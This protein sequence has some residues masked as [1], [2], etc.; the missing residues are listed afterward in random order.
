MAW[1]Q[2]WLTR[3]SRVPCTIEE[4]QAMLKRLDNEV[5]IYCFIGYKRSGGAHGPGIQKD[6]LWLSPGFLRPVCRLAAP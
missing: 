3:A 4:L 6:K 1:S 2:T 5:S